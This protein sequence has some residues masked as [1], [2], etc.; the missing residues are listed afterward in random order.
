MECRGRQQVCVTQHAVPGFS[1]L[2]LLIALALTSTIATSAALTLSG[3]RPRFQL[4]LAARQVAAD[5]AQARVRA[6]TTTSDHRVRFVVGE[7]TYQLQHLVDS[8]FEPVGTAI[9]LPVGVTVASCTA[10]DQ[11]PRFGSRGTATSFGTVVLEAG[12]LSAKIVLSMTGHARV[13]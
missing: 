1:I 3:A 8:S 13:E 6:V 10:R 12:S 5:L 2:E 11:A 9:S 4:W 7:R